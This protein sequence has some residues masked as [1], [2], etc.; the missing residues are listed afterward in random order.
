MGNKIIPFEAGHY[1]HL[2]NHGIGEENIFREGRNYDFF[3]DRFFDHLYKIISVYSYCL[4]PNHFHF[5]IQLNEEESLRSFFSK[6]Y[7]AKG[8]ND[9]QDL[10]GLVA[11]QIGNFL[12]AYAKSYNNMYDRNGSLFISSVKRKKVLSKNYLLELIRYI[13]RNPIHHGFAKEIEDWG[14]S[15]YLTF[16][17]QDEERIRKEEVLSWFGGV[18]SFI[19]FHKQPITAGIISEF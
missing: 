9:F 16:L 18:D 17:G 5:L 7:P 15:S 3:I 12:N 8:K 10:S 6:K 1:Y 14:F 2:Y 4:M 11:Q 13:H 19:E